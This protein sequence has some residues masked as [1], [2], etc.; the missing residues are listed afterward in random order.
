MEAPVEPVSAETA[1]GR[2]ADANTGVARGEQF[3]PENAK[4]TNASAESPGRAA[5]LRAWLH[6]QWP[7]PFRSW[8]SGRDLGVS[9]AVIVLLVS[10]VV[11]VQPPHELRMLVEQSSTNLANMASHPLQVLVFSAF[12][13]SPAT[14]LV[15]LV[16]LVI[17]F[18]EVERWLGRAALFVI[19]VFGHIGATLVV[20]TI[21][22]T[23]LH[24]RLVRFSVVIRPD[25]GVSYA[26]FAAIGVLLVR[27]PRRWRLAYGLAS[28]AVIAILLVWSLDFT[29]VG[30]ATAWLIGLALGLVAQRAERAD[31]ARLTGRA[32]PATIYSKAK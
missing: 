2:P 27:V 31:G 15:L 22:I 11:A 4:V 1:R 30:H 20:M 12:V 13:V 5:E 21:Q 8:W 17:A 26:M 25:V 28:L 32:Q 9:Y 24:R 23:A 10:V 18:G 14:G 16:P 6:S 19:A 7:V 29:N 3:V